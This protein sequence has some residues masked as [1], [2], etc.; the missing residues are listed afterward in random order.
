MVYTTCGKMLG[1]LDPIASV[2]SQKKLGGMK[3]HRNQLFPVGGWPTPL[4]IMTVSW[5]VYSQQ[6]EKYRMFQTT[7]QMAFS[8]TWFHLVALLQINEASFAQSFMVNLRYLPQQR[9]G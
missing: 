2:A 4:K 3:P 1:M 9:A 8:L 6:M 7:N 5:D